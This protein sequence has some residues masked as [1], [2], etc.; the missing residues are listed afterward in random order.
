MI[1]NSIL[2]QKGKI[3]LQSNPSPD[4]VTIQLINNIIS[5]L[6]PNNRS[7]IK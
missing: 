1:L 6:S 7:C 2:Y 4:P 5:S 3:L